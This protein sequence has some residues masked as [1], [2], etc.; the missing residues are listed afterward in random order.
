MYCHELDF[1][2]DDKLRLKLLQQAKENTFKYH[3]SILSKQKT[4]YEVCST[5][6]NQLSVSAEMLE[7][8]K[9]ITDTE[10]VSLVYNKHKI[11]IN[12]ANKTR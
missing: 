2:F 4:N 1:Q 12:H 7:A 6:D 3:Q 10:L 9:I 8:K 11:N 5:Y